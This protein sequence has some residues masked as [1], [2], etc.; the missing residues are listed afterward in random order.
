MMSTHLSLAAGL[1]ACLVPTPFGAEHTLPVGQGRRSLSTADH[2][3]PGPCRGEPTRTG[4]QLVYDAPV[5]TRLDNPRLACVHGPCRGSSQVK[6]VAVVLGG[7]RARAAFDVWGGPTRWRLTVDL[8][9]HDERHARR[10]PEAPAPAA[11]AMAR[12]APAVGPA[13]GRRPPEVRHLKPGP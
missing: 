13:P 2:R 3:C 7:A 4:Y 5:G 1:L 11:S 9:R 6:R 10:L 12:A 8:F